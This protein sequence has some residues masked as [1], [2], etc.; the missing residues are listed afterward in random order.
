M[1]K[2]F[3]TVLLSVCVLTGYRNKS[4][5]FSSVET[6]VDKAIIEISSK[7][8]IPIE[9]YI[10]AVELLDKDFEFYEMFPDIKY[11]NTKRSPL[12]IYG[13]DVLKGSKN[14][15]DAL[16]ELY[17]QLDYIYSS[18]IN[19][20]RSTYG[21]QYTNLD[22]ETKKIITTIETIMIYTGSSDE[23][24]DKFMR[25]YDMSI[26]TDKSLEDCINDCKI[27]NSSNIVYINRLCTKYENI[28][29]S[30][31][32][33][34]CDEPHVYGKSSKENAMVAAMSIIG[35]VRYIWGGGHNGASAIGAINPCWEAFNRL[36][37]ES[38]NNSRYIGYNSYR[39][40]IHGD[41]GDITEEAEYKSCMEISGLYD[42]NSYLNSRSK[43]MDI[44]YASCEYIKS[45]YSENIISTGHNIDGLDCSGYISWILNQVDSSRIYDCTSST[46]KDIEG[47]EVIEF[48]N[49]LQTCDIFAWTNHVVMV[50]GQL[51]ENSKVYIAVE[52]APCTPRL[53]V[54]YYEGAIKSDIEEAKRI[55]EDANT[56]IAGNKLNVN[57][58]CMDHKGVSDETVEEECE[59]NIKQFR[60]IYR[61]GVEMEYS[62]VD[63]M[64][65]LDI[66]NTVISKLPISYLYGY[67]DYRG[68]LDTN[69]IATRVGL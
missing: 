56:L 54:I 57:I 63:S 58:Y 34:N 44:D 9:L 35:K 38:G 53:C 18:R 32:K 16:C 59:E 15:Y 39:C 27:C 4:L 3:V 67:E 30:N 20:V 7:G 41:S 19:R 8:D 14:I 40:H 28:L 5:A 24:A 33:L 51:N 12:K 65:A 61:L 36:Y 60:E 48:G 46:F 68:L 31:D 25:A 50:L 23:D 17:K 22:T 64:Y 43:I 66:I 13:N 21:E 45:K 47:I 6:K 69:C 2:L 42:I 26:C 29:S 49:E 11:D 1:K 52:Q 55:A 62:E 10:D 37:E